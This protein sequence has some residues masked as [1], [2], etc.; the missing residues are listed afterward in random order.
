MVGGMRSCA[1][2]V[3][4][5]EAVPALYA[6]S[7]FLVRLFTLHRRATPDARE[8]I[9]TVLSCKSFYEFFLGDQGGLA[10]LQALTSVAQEVSAPQEFFSAGLVKDN[11]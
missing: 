1:C 5:L 2:G 3:A 11:G 7:R 8:R 10:T 4:R 9:P 6:Y